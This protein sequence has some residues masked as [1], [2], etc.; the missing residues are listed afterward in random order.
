[1]FSYAAEQADMITIKTGNFNDIIAMKQYAMYGGWD[2]MMLY[3]RG[4][5]TKGVSSSYHQY[6]NLELPTSEI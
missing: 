4:A 1:M 2:G 5:G 3:S 6:H